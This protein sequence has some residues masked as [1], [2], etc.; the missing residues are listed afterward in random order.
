MSAIDTIIKKSKKFNHHERLINF[1]AYIVFVCATLIIA[2]SVSL[3]FLKSPLYGLIGIIPIVFY[4]PVPFFKRLASLEKKIGLH[5]E[6]INSIQLSLVPKDSKERY[7]QE[8]IKAYISDVAEK[9]KDIDFRKYLSYQPLLR[10]AGFLLISFVFVLIHPALLPGHFWYALNHQISYYAKPGNAEYLSGTEVELTLQLTGVY[11]PGHAEC[12][13][14]NGKDLKITKVALQ[15]GIAKK[16]IKLEE[17]IIYYFKFLNRKTE[18]FS[19]VTIEPLYIEALTFHLTYPPYTKLKDDI[20]T[21]R[22]IIAPKGTRIYIQGRAS[23][24]LKSARLLLPDTLDLEYDDKNF[25]GEFAI[26]ESGTAVLHLISSTQLKEQIIIYAIPDLLPLVDIFYPGYNINLP[27]DMQVDIGIRCSDDYGLAKGIFYYKFKE[28]NKK[29][30]SLKKGA[31]EDTIYFTWDLSELGMLPGDEISY[32]AVITDNAGNKATS[33]TYYIYFPTV[34]EIYKEITEKESMIETGLEDLQEK[35]TSE[36]E[37]IER[38]REKIM[39][40]RKLSW[41][42]QEK[43]KETI[44]KEKKILDK[45]DAWQTEFEKTLEKLNEGIIL[46]KESIERLQQIAEILREIAPDEL[47][48]ALEN[49]KSALDKRPQD[50]QKAL[51]NLKK[52]QEDLARALERTLEI[53]KRF[54]QEERLRELAEMAENLAREADELTKL[55]EEEN[56]DLNKE[57]EKL[58]KETER[59]AD[60]LKELAQSEGLEEYIRESLEK[61]GEQA[62]MIREYSPTSLGKKKKGL[63]QLAGELQKLYES[64]TKGRTAKLR[65]SLLEILNQLIDISKVEE[66]LYQKQTEFDV[67]HQ[68]QIIN[69]TKTVA[70]SLYAQQT[71]SL[72]V[73]PHMSKNIA[74]ALKHME[75]AKQPNVFKKSTQEAMQLINV[76]CLEMLRN[77]EKAAQAGSS[78]GMDKFLEELSDIAQGQ[79]SLNQS[80]SGFFPIPLGG[81]SSAQKAQIQRLAGRQRALREALEALRNETGVSKYQDFLDNVINE[82][83][84]IEESLYQYKINRELI[85]RQKMVMSRL[86]DAQKSIRKENYQKKRKSKPGKDFL[87]RE[88]PLPLPAELGKDELRALIQQAL[89]EFYPKEYELY[90]RE[91]FKRLLEEK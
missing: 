72:Y 71:K 18:N 57:I 4:R 89:R 14:S 54:Q 35:H 5:G 10:A 62:S 30:L 86:L 90:I 42:D 15:D 85:E 64:L 6:L 80:M 75:Q 39:K 68:D 37:E 84:K 41:A 34:E 73:T 61:F 40:E 91:Y 16:K 19:L 46:D 79:M 23:Q 87:T 26:R 45:I 20:K 76:V 3:Y 27:N 9:I 44:A 67:D 1:S 7:S 74:R 65:K 2:V 12:V 81:L 82:M 51:E 28:E 70:E 11:L 50:I 33:K 77:L 21:G 53:L 36:I 31:L 25:S 66:E 8:L 47:K 22:Q 60:A 56:I 69:A 17:P 43:L 52:S 83:E 13:I 38:I 78:T 88:G 58:N 24:P 48:E 29:I 63:N 49:L 32:F 55:A 59:L